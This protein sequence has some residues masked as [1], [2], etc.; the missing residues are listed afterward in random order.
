MAGFVVSKSAISSFLLLCVVVLTTACSQKYQYIADTTRDAFLAD[1]DVSISTDDIK[2]LPYA[3]AFVWV[4]DGR[5]IFMVLALV[6]TVPGSGVQQLKWLS[7][8]K[9]V[10]VTEHGRI[11]KTLGFDNDNLAGF[12][13]VDGE[14]FATVLDDHL[15]F[16]QL[17]QFEQQAIYDWLPGY[18]YNFPARLSMQFMGDEVVSTELWSQRT[19]HIVE[20][21]SFPTLRKAEFDNHYWVNDA[22]RVVKTI[23]HIGPGMDKV[24]I[25][26]IKPL[27]L[28]GHA[29]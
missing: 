9:G 27:V 8:D 21:V 24:E 19:K 23:Q 7:A 5:K 28:D 18:R 10:L 3:S 4:N 12:S 11:V 13:Y 22:G 1:Q 29:S 17:N 20:K 26:Y 2:A 14:S 25:L 16:G 6:D 15:A